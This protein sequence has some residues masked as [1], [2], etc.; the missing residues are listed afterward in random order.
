VLLDEIGE[1]PLPLQAKL[2]RVIQTRQVTR[3]GALKPRVIDV[4][5]VAATNKDLQR[6]VAQEQF[7]ADLYFRLNGITLH[8]PPLRER[9]S[10]ILP[11][12]RTFAAQMAAAMNRDP[13][14]ELSAEAEDLLVGYA[15]PGNIRELRNVVE[16]ALLLCEGK[17][18]TAEHLPVEMMTP[19]TP[20]LATDVDTYAAL[21]GGQAAA[22]SPAQEDERQRILCALAEHAGNQSRAARKLGM[23]RSTL[24]QRLKQYHI[25]RPRT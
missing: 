3:V 4:R 24:V 10:E 5:F 6:Q 20:L 15:W 23:S 13:P 8:V 16:R 12:A 7:R 1:M 21:F 25:A 17:E 18:I 19:N 14:P 11:M 9:P 2:L 22:S